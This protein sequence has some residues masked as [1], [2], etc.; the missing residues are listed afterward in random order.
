MLVLGIREDEARQ[1]KASSAPIAR[2]SKAFRNLVWVTTA[3]TYI[4]VYLGA[5][6]SHTD[7]AGGCLGW[8]LC[9]G[10]LIPELSGGVGIAFLHRVAAALLLI[11]VAIMG[12][13]AYWK[14]PDNREVRTLGLAATIL[15]VIQ[16][17]TGASIVFTMNNYHVYLF[18]SLAHIVVLAALF[19][20][21]AYLCVRAWQMSRLPND[22]N[23]ASNSIQS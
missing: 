7:S 13:I 8:P 6:V 17:F 5:Y 2:V 16:I 3:Y 10:Q 21:L 22:Q 18:T 11:L 23:Q 20:V 1:G 15:S 9:N 14:H 19:G 4:V 12:H